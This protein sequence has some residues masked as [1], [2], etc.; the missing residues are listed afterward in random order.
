M[1]NVLSY[2]NTGSL[3]GGTAGAFTPPPGMWCRPAHK[4]TQCVLI[5]GDNVCCFCV[6]TTATCFVIEMWGQG[7]GGGGGCCCGVGSYG[8]QGGSYGFVACT[9]SGQNWILCACVCNCSCTTCTI[10]TG[11]NGQFARVCQCNGG[12]NGTWWCICGGC[13]GYWCCNPSAPW[14]WDGGSQNPGA[15]PT[16]QKYNMW[17]H[18]KDRSACLAGRCSG[19]TTVGPAAGLPMCTNSGVA[20][21]APVAATYTGCT[22]T[23]PTSPNAGSSGGNILDIVFPK[24]TCACFQP[25]GYIWQGACGFSDPGLGNM[26][27]SCLNTGYFNSSIPNSACGGGMGVGGS[28]Y[29]GGE[30]AWKK[31]GFDCGGCWPQNGNFPGG[32]GMSTH[33]CSAWSHPGCGA[34]GL[35]LMSYC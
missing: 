21:Q 29:A 3:T 31:C 4:P 9:I 20:G 23:M 17:L 24:K 12:V 6:P 25:L 8:G 30:Q 14:C 10:C 19:T 26:P 27:A 1:A 16:G 28:A 32:G 33:S 18:W 2:I 34:M 7:G 5:T 15:W 35:I 11:T 13:E 22:T